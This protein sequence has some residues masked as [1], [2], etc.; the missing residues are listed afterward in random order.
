MDSRHVVVGTRLGILDRLGVD[1]VVLGVEFLLNGPLLFIREDDWP[2]PVPTEEVLAFLEPLVQ[3]LD[4]DVLSTAPLVRLD[5]QVFHQGAIDGPLGHIQAGCEPRRPPQ[6]PPPQPLPDL[7]NERFRSN[8]TWSSRLFAVSSSALLP[9]PFDG[10][11]D[12]R[13]GVTDLAQLAKDGG[14]SVALGA[15]SHDVLS[16]HFPLRFRRHGI[17]CS[18]RM[19]HI[20]KALNKSFRL[21]Y[22]SAINYKSLK[23]FTPVSLLMANPVNS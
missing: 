1:S 20:Q 12:E 22:I 9:P 17:E 10:P 2:S 8:R 5:S 16:S 7:L 23:S 6:L 18:L 11:I 3:V 19:L 14:W 21:I 13:K 4:R 15:K